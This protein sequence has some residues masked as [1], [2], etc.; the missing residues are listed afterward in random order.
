MFLSVEFSSV[1]LWLWIIIFAATIL[2]ELITV[3]LMC[4]WFS[5]GA[6][7]AFILELLG[8]PEW[9]QVLVFFIISL[10][11]IFTVGKWARKLLKSKQN[12]NVNALIGQDIVVTKKTEHYVTGEGKVNGIVWTTIT[13]ENE[14][15]EEGE[16]AVINE[17]SG[18]KL[19]I[20]R[21]EK[22]NI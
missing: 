3:D 21:K 4:I 12:T 5:I 9:V 18:N 10:S 11:L 16:I 19:Y 1:I 14:V 8:A 17:I 6:L 20:K 7:L 2:I 22:G 15:V 13:Y